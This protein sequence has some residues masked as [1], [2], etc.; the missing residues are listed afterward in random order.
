M[1][2]NTKSAAKSAKCKKNKII[3]NL[4]IIFFLI[5][6]GFISSFFVDELLKEYSFGRQFKRFLVNLS[7][8]IIVFFLSLFYFFASI[9]FR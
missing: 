8:W 9:T 1:E 5:A 7:F 3:V 4:L 6:F 2:L